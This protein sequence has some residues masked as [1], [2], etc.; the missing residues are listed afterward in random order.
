ME[1]KDSLEQDIGTDL[2][3]PGSLVGRYRLLGPLATG[4]MA[5]IWAA[6]NDQNR[7]ARTI[8]LKVIRPE[9]AAD[10]EYRRMLVDEA[11]AA[12]AVHHPNVCEILELGT[13]KDVLFLA[14]EWVAGDSLAGLIR[15]NGERV[16]FPYPLAARIIANACSG[17]HAAHE[18]LAPD[19]HP[20]HIV[21]RDI[22]PQNLLLSVS[23]QVKVSDFGIA[24][25]RDQLHARTRTGNI[26]GKFAYIPPEQIRGR[27]VDRRADVYA[28]G[29][30][31]YV[32]TTGLRPFGSGPH[33]ALAKILRGDFKPPSAVVPGYPR[34]LE[35]IILKAI[36]LNP[37]DRFQ[38]ADELR[39]ELER[40]L[41]RQGALLTESD[42]AS[43][44]KGRLSEAA[45]HQ[46]R[47]L[48]NAPQ[49]LREISS[50]QPKAPGEDTET[51]TAATGVNS[52]RAPSYS[53]GPVDSDEPTKTT[54]PVHSDP[55]ELEPPAP[56]PAN[57]SVYPARVS[58]RPDANG[59]TTSVRST[60][61]P[62]RRPPRRALARGGGSMSPPY[63]NPSQGDGVERAGASGSSAEPTSIPAAPALSPSAALTANPASTRW[64][65]FPLSWFRRW[66]AK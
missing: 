15:R 41:A 58:V 38:S 17:L 30:V 61:P 64:G 43:G 34:S 1:Q 5:Q 21:H 35:A 6:R 45:R 7:F 57:R 22:S 63:T 16:P 59:R 11:T 51:P 31:L 26:K 44:V 29:C 10:D 47:A 40:W 28:M 14:M 25:A 39:L 54:A 2:F 3:Q 48:R 50:Y 42:I 66:R 62:P 32:A 65:F 24:K 19:G 52:P 33:A 20:L 8:V 55:T 37:D 46:I 60:V 4:G 56:K 18:A 13:H 12:S 27:G 53:G 36:R 49:F 9:Y 23:G